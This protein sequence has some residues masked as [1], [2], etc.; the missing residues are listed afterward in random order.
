M[1]PFNP[2]SIGFTSGLRLRSAFDFSS[3]PSDISYKS[4]TDFRTNPRLIDKYTGSNISIII[5]Y[6]PHANIPIRMYG[7]IFIKNV[8]AHKLHDL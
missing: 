1:Y 8:V 2:D 7:I 3:D 6:T 4:D 5:Y